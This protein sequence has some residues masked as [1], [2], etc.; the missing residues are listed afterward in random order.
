MCG[1]AGFFARNNQRISKNLVISM[2]QKLKHRGPDDEG[3]FANGEFAFGHTRLSI[4]DIKGG[5]Q[6]CSNEDESVVVIFNGEIYNYKELREELLSRSHRFHSQSDTEVIVHLYE[7]EGIGMF[8]QLNGMFAIAIADL[9]DKKLILARDHLGKKPLFYYADQNWVVFASELKAIILHP[10]VP[11]NL[12][13]LALYN[14][15]SLNYIPGTRTMLDGVRRVPPGSYILF[16]QRDIR[17]NIF[18]S[19]ES[20][21]NETRSKVKE[22]EAIEELDSL[23]TDSVRIRLRS[24]VPVG[25]FL[26][27]GVDSSLIA[28]K[29]KSLGGDICAYTASFSE[30]SF[31]E[32]IYAKEIAQLLNMDIKIYKIDLDKAGES[33]FYNLVY[34]ADDPLADSSSFPVY[35]LSKNASKDVKVVLG[36]DGGDE[37]FAGYL[38]YQATLLA[39]KIRR[40]IPKGLLKLNNF[41]ANQLPISNKKVSLEY[42]IKRFARGLIMYPGQAHFSW[43]GTWCGWRKNNLLSYDF[44]SKLKNIQDTYEYLSLKYNINSHNPTLKDIQVADICE[45]LPNDILAK[46]DRM[47]MAHGLEVRSPWLDHRIVEWALT[48]PSNLKLKKDMIGKY[49]LKRY[50]GKVFPSRLV[51]RPKSGFSVP[52]HTWIRQRFKPLV[53]EYLSEKALKESGIFHTKNVRKVIQDHYDG[54]ASFGF[55]IWGLLVFMLWYK[56]FLNTKKG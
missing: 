46:V 7:E 21:C 14:Y 31:S 45:Y 5:K 42:K 13:C 17:Q 2:A 35:L 48:L 51:H 34:Y 27:G 24:D 9:R 39:K 20:F 29:A 28:W 37:L 38:T 52:V 40:H 47:S 26:S 30:R 8:S 15:L 54:K 41:L 16:T 36:G 3:V 56:T 53:E 11:R 19:I 33:I 32:E 10:S 44:L 12:D 22:D 43:N 18:W 1:I 4:I 6:P 49:L 50:M 25:I 23:L 55:E